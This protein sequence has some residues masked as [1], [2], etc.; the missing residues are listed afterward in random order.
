M[1]TL[2]EAFVKVKQDIDFLNKK[3]EFL[4]EDLKNT[5]E[6]L[7]K[8]CEILKEITLINKKL[9]EQNKLFCTQNL[10]NSNL[11]DSVNSL[12]KKVEE[13]EVIF[14]NQLERLNQ[15]YF[16][17]SAYQPIYSTHIED[18]PTYNSN[19]KPQNANILGIS[20]GNEGVPTDKQT[21]QQ[22]NQQ[23]NFTLKKEISRD[24]E[25]SVNLNKSSYNIKNNSIN[26]A[27][28]ILDSLDNIKKDIRLKFKRLTDQEL[29]VFS[30]I[31]QLDEENGSSDYKILSKRLNL[32]ESSIRDYVGRLTKKGI[33]IE[34]IKINNKQIQLNISN[35]LKKIAT[36]NT[37]LQLR[38]I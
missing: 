6:E 22:T 3:F 18:S 14:L 24:F 38:E 31:Y 8:V 25:T 30:A 15:V 10:N 34:K 35:N 9:E 11:I 28:E 4:S 37:I 2:K 13:K 23:T 12:F 26:N 1:D 19:F 36:L 16:N 5:K 20:S 17:N 32:T 27:I 21:N 29:T 7:S 33:P